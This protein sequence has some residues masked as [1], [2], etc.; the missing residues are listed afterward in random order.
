MVEICGDIKENNR[1]DGTKYVCQKDK[2][3]E[4]NH[5]YTWKE[6]GIVRI[7]GV[8]QEGEIELMTWW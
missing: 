8:E 3:H 4:G 6:K 2:G 1:K 7:D 5:T